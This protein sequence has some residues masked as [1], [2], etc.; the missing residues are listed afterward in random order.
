MFSFIYVLKNSAGNT[1]LY[2]EPLLLQILTINQDSSV[3]A[4]GRT[5]KKE[6]YTED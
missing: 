5:Y 4:T 1:L 3:E 6:F 2:S